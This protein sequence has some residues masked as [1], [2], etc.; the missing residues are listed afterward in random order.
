MLG[1]RVSIAFLVFVSLACLLSCGGLVY[2]SPSI[3]VSDSGTSAVVSLNNAENLYAY[4]I[5]FD[6]SGTASASFGSFLGA[7]TSSGTNTKNSVLYVY[8]SKLDSSRAGVTGSGNPFNIS[9]SGSFNLTYAT[10]IY[11][12]TSSYSIDYSYCGDGTCDAGETCTLDNCYSG[13]RGNDANT[14]DPTCRDGDNGEVLCS[15]DSG[16]TLCSDNYCRTSCGT[17]VSTGESAGGGGGGGGGGA[18]VPV[19]GGLIVDTSEI[20]V[21]MLIGSTR[22]KIIKVTNSGNKTENIKTSSGSLG[23]KVTFSDKSFVLSP[24]ETKELKIFISSGNNAEIITGTLNVGGKEILLAVNVKSQKLLFDAMI[25]VPDSSKQI[26]PNSKLNAQV[27]LIPMGENPRVDVTLNY[28]VKDYNGKVYMKES[29]TILVDSQKSFK[30]QFYTK[31][32]PT[33]NYILGL[34]LVYPNGVATSSSHFEIA[35]NIPVSF[36]SILIGLILASIVVMGLIVWFIIRIGRKK[37]VLL[38]RA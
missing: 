19:V 12:D 38:R 20:N 7:G 24:G 11:N 21:D 36:Q 8:E 17:S 31:D 10:F 33:G 6:Y 25:V 29:E 28:I 2:A 34:E 9:H 35:E 32:L 26:K 15:C 37:K 3:S 14:L 23:N 18:P 4:E 5:N 1:K 16:Y 30:K 22:E 27:T 13:R